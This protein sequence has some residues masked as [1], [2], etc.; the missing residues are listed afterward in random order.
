MVENF[1]TPSI[2][3]K[4]KNKNKTIF[5]LNLSIAVAWYLPFDQQ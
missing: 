4:Y 1:F 3:Q 2:M 5:K